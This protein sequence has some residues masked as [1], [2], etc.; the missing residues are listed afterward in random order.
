MDSFWDTPFLVID[1]E[2]TG[3][4]AEH[5]RITEIACVT[6]L[7]GEIVSEFSSLVNPHQFIP[8]FIE[9]M[10]GITNEMAANAPEP[11]EI[12]PTVEEILTDSEAVFAAHNAGF[13][14]GFV[15]HSLMRYGFR[16]PNMDRLCTLKLARRI[17]PQRVKKNVGNLANYLSVKINN[18]HRALGDAQAT[19]EIL[20]E[21]LERAEQ[22]HE[23]R[24]TAQILKFQNKPVKKI[25]PPSRNYKKIETLLEQVPAQPGVYYFYN[26]SGEIL[27]VGKAKSLKNRVRSYFN[28]SAYSSKKV[29]EMVRKIDKIDWECTGTELAALLLESKEIKKYTPGFNSMEKRYRKFPFLKLTINEDFPRIEACRTMEHDGAEYY[30]PFRSMFLVDSIIKIIDRKFKLRNCEEPFSPSPGNKPCF[31]YQIKRCDAP[32]ALM[33]DKESYHEEVQHVRNFLRGYSDGVVKQLECQMYEYADNLE[34]EKAAVFK[35]QL[36]DLKKVLGR[37]RNVPTSINEN[38]VIL[39]I[40][41]SESEKTLEIF[42]IKN[43]RLVHQQQIGRRTPLKRISRLI[44]DFYFNGYAAPM[45]YTNQ[46]ID[47]LRIIS[48]WMFRQRDHAQFVYLNGKPEVEIL[49]DLEYAVRN[50]NY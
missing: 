34:F 23:M 14:W 48:G 42:M 27:Y 6:V 4:H 17:L 50:V 8:S 36:M 49:K 31:Y 26:K 33:T 45:F 16:E 25:K 20:I 47:E 12:Y 19:A 5:N 22:E 3:S 39:V 7:G 28:Y 30:G 32:C 43:G 10:T 41:A 11:E 29:A 15:K 2:T 46:D 37:S 38:D 35:R 21:L 40:P 1:V 44:R 9:N 18:R 24:T 13:D